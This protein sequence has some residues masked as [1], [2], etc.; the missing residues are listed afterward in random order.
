M[1]AFDLQRKLLAMSTKRAT[2]GEP[3][4]TTTKKKVTANDASPYRDDYDD[5]DDDDDDDRFSPPALVHQR[6]TTSPKVHQRKTTSPVKPPRPL[7]VRYREPPVP[8]HDDDDAA[9]SSATRDTALR[10][11]STGDPSRTDRVHDALIDDAAACLFVQIIP[12]QRQKKTYCRCRRLFFAGGL[13]RVNLSTGL[14]MFA[15]VC[16][17]IFIADSVVIGCARVYVS[18]SRHDARPGADAGA[19]RLLPA[20]APHQQHSPGD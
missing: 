5:D 18:S 6:K 12:R 9:S 15:V 10:G 8:V 1:P 3:P 11:A 4:G 2:N 17:P 16:L 19:F 7:P 14:Q 13:L 20:W